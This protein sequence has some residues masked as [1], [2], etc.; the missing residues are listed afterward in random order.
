MPAKDDPVLLV[1]VIVPVRDGATDLPA[2]LACLEDQTL[3]RGLFEIII[4]DDGSTDGGTDA[5]TSS[6][7]HIRVAHGE[8]ENSYAARNRAVAAS[9]APILAFCDADCRPEPS[10]LEQGLSALA[11]AD[12]VA[13]RIRFSVP[14]KR[15]VWTLLDMDGSKD[16][17][18]QVRQ[19]VAE[20][21][22]LFVPRT[23]FE[24]V[25]G[26]DASIREHGDFDFVE[27][28]VASGA[29]LVFAPEAVVWHPTRTRAR[30]FLRATWIYNHGYA[31]R[32]TRAGR[33]PEGLRLRSLVPLVQ[34]IRARRRWG[35]SLGPDKQWLGEN[36]VV[37]TTGE[38]LRAL[39]LMYLFIP[40]FRGAAQFQGWLV[41]RRLR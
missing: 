20:T 21:A 7:D 3:S 30:S 16:H 11:H 37:V 15:T 32:D 40:Y 38:K 24:R 9:H 10:W 12:V 33:I 19:G 8:P 14:D 41:G 29:R 2:L 36:G 26:F 13:G 5:I 4:G 31:V 28:C 6:D 17:E 27:R 18:R 23:V 25:R 1:S 22:N 35:R 39:P 34:P